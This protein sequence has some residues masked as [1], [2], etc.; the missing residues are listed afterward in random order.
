VVRRPAPD[1]VRV[2]D[3][4]QQRHER[5]PERTLEVAEEPK[6]DRGRGAELREVRHDLEVGAAR[7]DRQHREGDPGAEQPTPPADG[8]C[9]PHEPEHRRDQP[10]GDEQHVRR[11]PEVRQFAEERVVREQRAEQREPGDEPRR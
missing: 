2:D 6:C 3:R 5:D 4:D 8:E 1:G 11:R 7:D 9:E 10:E